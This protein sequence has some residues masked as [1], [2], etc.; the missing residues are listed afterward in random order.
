MLRISLAAVKVFLARLAE[1][2][3]RSGCRRPRS[4]LHTMSIKR[5]EAEVQGGAGAR[6]H[7]TGCAAGV[8]PGLE[9]GWCLMF[10]A[11]CRGPAG[12]PN[13][14]MAG[15]GKKGGSEEGMPRFGALVPRMNGHMARCYVGS[16]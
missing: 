7:R 13:A 9:Y 4:S 10:A 1:K 14:G 8:V 6:A 11:N 12:A 5:N 16:G 2:L 15:A 3:L